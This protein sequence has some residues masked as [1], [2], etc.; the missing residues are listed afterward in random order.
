[1]STVGNLW[2]GDNSIFITNDANSVWAEIYINPLNLTNYVTMAQQAIANPKWCCGVEYGDNEIATQACEDAGYI[3][4]SNTCDTWMRDFC[5][6]HPTD[7]LCACINS[8]VPM[9]Q[10]LDI[11]C[12]SSRAYRT[13]Q[14]LGE[15]KNLTYCSQIIADIDKLEPGAKANINNNNLTMM[16]GNQ[17]APV[18]DSSSTTET[19]I[20]EIIGGG[21][22]G[23][24]VII[25]LIIFAVIIG[26]ILGWTINKFVIGDEEKMRPDNL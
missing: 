20:S 25:L 5:K 11:K 14:N 4:A 6:K 1:M 16:C 18:P 26:L 19:E 22:S 7:P 9:P 24:L 13:Q 17:P 23:W 21:S 8:P 15:C 12:S 10:C 3:P 2:S